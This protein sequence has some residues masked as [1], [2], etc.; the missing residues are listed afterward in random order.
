MERILAALMFFTRLPFHR[1]R[2][3]SP[4]AFRHV[5]VYWPLA[6]YLT[7]G[8]MALVF[9][10]S[11]LVLP[12]M[13][14]IILAIASRLLLTNALHEDGLADFLDGMGGGSSREHTL[15][16][17]KDSHIGSFGTIGLI[18]YFLLFIQV[19]HIPSGIIPSLL[20]SADVFSKCV[21]SHIVDVLPYARK[22]EEAKNKTVYERMS[23]R[24]FVLNVTLGAAPALLVLPY[25]YYPALLSSILLFFLLTGIMRKKIQGYT[26]D[27]CG[28]LFLI[29][30]VG[31]LMTFLAI[32]YVS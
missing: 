16:I 23:K 18:I 27:C 17:M 2:Q 31:L 3:V 24:D 7:G 15:M 28:A 32:S 8:L 1:I 21:A 11:S 6:G 5:T 4:Q 20:F 19:S 9:F 30:E 26:G 12:P 13:T 10:L 22:Q 29:I 14:A 25:R